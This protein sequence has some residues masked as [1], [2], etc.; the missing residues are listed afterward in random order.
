MR[1]LQMGLVATTL[2]A[3]TA[4]ADWQYT[5]WGMTPEQVVAASGG[6]AQLLPEADRPRLPP[7]MTAAAGTYQDGPIPMRVAFSFNIQS[8]GLVCVTYGLNGHDND[9]AFKAALV[10]RYGPPEAASGVAFL[11]MSNLVWKTPTDKIEATFAKDDPAY[12]MQCSIK[13]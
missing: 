5:R 6:A 11:S 9:E 4:R 10:K 2:I 8:G 3:P 12:A 1:V 13:K 7:M